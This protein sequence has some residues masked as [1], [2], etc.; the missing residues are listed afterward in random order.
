MAAPL[1]LAGAGLHPEDGGLV[2]ATSTSCMNI[3]VDFSKPTAED[4]RRFSGV[5]GSNASRAVLFHRQVNMRGGSFTF[6]YRVIRENAD[7][8][9]EWKEVTSMRRRRCANLRRCR[10][11]ARL[12][13]AR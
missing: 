8:A 5:P 12:R 4:F 7:V 13:R 1:L 2:A 6:L 3:P 11:S 10:R 9:E